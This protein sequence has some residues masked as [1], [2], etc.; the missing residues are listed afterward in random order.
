VTTSALLVVASERQVE[1]LGRGGG[2]AITR[3]RLRA[4]L[5]EVA[6]RDRLL[7]SPIT[8]RLALADVLVRAAPREPI[9][10]SSAREG[11][12]AWGRTVDAIS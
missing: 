3:E 2:R 6:C 10:L 7:A 12:E 11:G 9:L 4:H 8:T 5:F 1:R